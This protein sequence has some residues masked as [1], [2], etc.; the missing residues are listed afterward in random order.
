VWCV[1]C[2]VYILL[3][4]QSGFQW[5]YIIDK[6]KSRRLPVSFGWRNVNF[7]FSFQFSFSCGHY[8]P[9][10][11][12]RGVDY[13]VA[14]VVPFLANYK[15]VQVF[16]PF[17]RC[18]DYHLNSSQFAFFFF[19]FVSRFIFWSFLFDLAKSKL[20]ALLFISIQDK[21]HE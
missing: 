14:T 20:N 17:V 2:F 1:F 18:M 11:G 6:I 9:S 4:H 15:K 19:T 5:S 8:S 13:W 12:A 21:N 10:R 3:L 16:W 7:F